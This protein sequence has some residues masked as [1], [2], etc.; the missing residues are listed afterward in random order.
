[1]PDAAGVAFWYGLYNVLL[2]VG[3][4]ACLPFWLFVRL[5]RGRYR[6]QF[7]QRMGIL[8]PE[9]VARFKGRP[10]VWIHAASA[11]E[12]ASAAPLVARLK[13]LLPDRPFLFTFTSR[14]GK[15]MAER[16]LG[17]IVDGVSFSPLD[18]PLFCVRFLNRIRP[19]LYVMVETDIWPNLVRGAKRRGVPVAIASGHAGPRSF[20]RAFWKVVFDQVDLLLMQTEVD[21]ENIRRRGAPPERVHVA[22]NLKFDS[23]ADRLAPAEVLAWRAELGLPAGVPVFVAGSTLA[24]DEAPVLDA[25]TALRRAGVDL[26]AIVAP[27]RQERVPEVEKACAGHGLA[28]IRRTRGGSAPVLILDTM[29]ELARSYNVAD[30]AYVGGGLTPEVGLHNL[31]E[32][33]VCGAPVLFGPHRGKARRIAEE[34]LRSGAGVEVADG[35]GLRT[36]LRVLLT[37][38]GRHAALVACGAEMLAHHEGAAHRQAERIRG[39]VP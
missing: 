30:V 19:C 32:P 18:L 6:G 34:V 27:R 35:E 8:P 15:E 9:F 25:V 10:A 5:A 38:A 21:A 2:H 28:A 16:R 17:A 14:Y 1:M 33:L 36:T 4:L 22:G 24:E 26:H 12:T 29:G 20:P 13:E 39:L 7:F 3:V 11:G 23:S 31:L 37:D